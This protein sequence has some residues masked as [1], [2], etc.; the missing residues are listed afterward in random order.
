MKNSVSISS[1]IMLTAAMLF[2]GCGGLQ[3]NSGSTTIT[4]RMTT[5]VPT[6][7]DLSRICQ[8][9]MDRFNARVN[10]AYKMQ[11]FPGGQLA[12]M[13]ESLDAIRTGA[14]EGGVIPLAAFSGTAPGFGLA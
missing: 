2:C 7:D 8:E 6:G 11:M 10:G 13:P 3:K 14:V 12:S 1:V 4:I 5:P 9:G